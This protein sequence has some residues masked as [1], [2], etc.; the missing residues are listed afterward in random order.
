MIWPATS[1]PHDVQRRNTLSANGQASPPAGSSTY[2]DRTPS[3]VICGF[4]AN[5]PGNSRV[6]AA[7]SEWR[8]GFQLEK[9]FLY[10]T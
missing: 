1:K 4:C 3:V 6:S 7:R 8:M 2:R 10:V 9:P 5:Y